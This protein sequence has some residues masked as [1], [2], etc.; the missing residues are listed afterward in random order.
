MTLPEA[1]PSSGRNRRVRHH[2]EPVTSCPEE[3]GLPL[4]GLIPQLRRQGVIEFMESRRTRLGPVFRVRMGTRWAVVVS[5]PDAFERVLVG[6]K[7]RYVKGNV[8]DAPREF[9]GL[10]L[11]TLEGDAWKERRRLMQP[12]F[13]RAALETMV[14]TMVDVIDRFLEDL[15]QRFPEGG[16]IDMHH[17]MVRLTLEVACTTLFGPRV[18]ARDELPFDVLGDIVEVMEARQFHPLPRWVPTATNRWFRR[19]RG[20]VDAVIHQAIARARSLRDDP[21][22]RG[23]LLGMLLDTTDEHGRP[24]SDEAIRD[25]LVTLY[26]AGHETTALTM[27]WMFALLGDAPDVH[28]RLAAECREL[29]GERRPGFAD[30][31]ELG[32]ARMVLEQTLRL[33]SIP[34]IIGRNVVEADNVCGHAVGP[35][36]VLMLW[37]WGLHRHEPSWPDP[38]RFDPERFAPE[39][40]AERD[41]WTYLPFSGGPRMCIGNS[42]ALYEGQLIASMMMQ[43]AEWEVV[44][45]QRIEPVAEGTLRPSAPVR[46]RFC[47]R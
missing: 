15:R 40:K 36:D 1:T 22:H 8:Y 37:F 43:R 46:V 34:P 28:E 16:E 12:Y 2:P 45:D 9:L 24:L 4:V 10:G 38:E 13:H 21:V 26:V 47:W 19:V 41:P 42:F 20:A 3:R 39:A 32:Y 11:V 35:G 44:P 33:R 27:T 6:H 7:R 25:E 18:T 29:L 17:E 5:H 14:G 31:S 23:T 30:L